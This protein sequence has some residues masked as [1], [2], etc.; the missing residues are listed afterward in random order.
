MYNEH[1]SWP[2]NV[3]HDAGSF[4]KILEYF[5]HAEG[6]VIM[7]S[8]EQMVLK[9]KLYCLYSYNQLFQAFNI[10]FQNFAAMHS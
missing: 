7:S 8:A 6:A 3:Y 2:V 10:F 1:L 9:E 5:L 4:Q